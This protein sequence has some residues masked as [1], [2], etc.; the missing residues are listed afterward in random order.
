ME[1]HTTRSLAMATGIPQ[2]RVTTLEHQCREGM[3]VNVPRDLRTGP[4]VY[5][6]GPDIARKNGFTQN[7]CPFYAPTLKAIAAT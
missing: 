6:A 1:K 3:I 5:P 7:S 4:M 2:F